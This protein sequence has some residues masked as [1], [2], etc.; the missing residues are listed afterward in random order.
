MEI[1]E[2]NKL[3]AVFMG[4]KPFNSP[5]GASGFYFKKKDMSTWYMVSDLKYHSDW[6]KIIP[7]CK[8]IQKSLIGVSKKVSFV[9]EGRL[10]SAILKLDIELTHER[11]GEF[12]VWYNKNLKK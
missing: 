9:L 2:I 1:E 5:Y 8:K 11:V 6:N 10:N 7:V 4:L 12:I 3:I